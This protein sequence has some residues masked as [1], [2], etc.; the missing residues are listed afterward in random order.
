MNHHIFIA[1]T[2]QGTTSNDSAFL[3]P[4]SHRAAGQTHAG[5]APRSTR[6]EDVWDPA[7]RRFVPSTTKARANDLATPA[8]GAAAIVAVAPAAAAATTTAT[9]SP[10]TAATETAGFITTSVSASNVSGEGEYYDPKLR[11]LLEFVDLAIDINSVRFFPTHGWKIMG[12]RAKTLE[13]GEKGEITGRVLAIIGEYKVGKTWL[14]RMILGMKD[15][16]TSEIHTPGIC[17]T[18]VEKPSTGQQVK[19]SPSR[20]RGRGRGRGRPSPPTGT[21]PQ[22]KSDYIVLDSAGTETACSEWCLKDTRATELILRKILVSAAS[23]LVYVTSRFN[24]STQ[25]AIRAVIDQ[26]RQSGKE[27]T[28]GNRLLVVHNMADVIK[29]P[30]LKTKIKEV[31]EVYD[32]TDKGLYDEGWS[33]ED[34]DVSAWTKVSKKVTIQVEGGSKTTTYNYFDARRT[35]HV[36]LVNHSLD[37]EPD[38]EDPRW[39]IEYNLAGIEI[40]KDVLFFMTNAKPINLLDTVIDVTEKELNKFVDN[41]ENEYKIDLATFDGERYLV[42]VP[43]AATTTATASA[44]DTQHPQSASTLDTSDDSA[45]P[46][47]DADGEP[48]HAAGRTTVIEE[49]SMSVDGEDNEQ[50]AAPH[51]PTD[52]QQQPF[53][54]NEVTFTDNDVISENEQRLDGQVWF[55]EHEYLIT[56]PVPGIK[57]KTDITVTTTNFQFVRIQVTKPSPLAAFERDPANFTSESK[58]KRW[59][60]SIFTWRAPAGQL[61]ENLKRDQKEAASELRDG[62]FLVRLQRENQEA[63]EAVDE[64]EAVAVGGAEAREVVGEVVGDADTREG[65]NSNSE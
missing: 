9:A 15:I 53:T 43:R 44:K 31:K 1:P 65:Y 42:P 30:V 54:L 16:D 55:N 33:E 19:A 2:S 23:R 17:M 3:A 26:L 29:R 64:G 39:R 49:L 52:Q 50:F 62:I 10:R 24:R 28:T 45:V 51:N 11:A 21:A 60:R 27:I 18:F 5:S 8:A 20:G 35:T 12:R 25:I 40:I 61:F 32:P 48:E 13:R 36:F 22:Q 14:Q 47:L 57:N 59:G 37:A 6:D 34:N 7:G 41:F 63:E 56:V 46:G 58:E 4:T 38:A